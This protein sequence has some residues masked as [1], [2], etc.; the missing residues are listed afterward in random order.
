MLCQDYEVTC[1]V[2]TGLAASS[3]TGWREL[4]LICSHKVDIQAVLPRAANQTPAIRCI[5]HRT[6]A[7]QECLEMDW[8]GARLIHIYH[9]ANCMHQDREGK[10]WQLFFIHIQTTPKVIRFTLSSIPCLTKGEECCTI[11]VLRYSQSRKGP[12]SYTGDACPH[13]PAQVTEKSRKVNG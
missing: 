9:C 4:S 12:R 11:G 5:L 2:I 3:L 10:R 6:M 13:S 1:A 8:G 7:S